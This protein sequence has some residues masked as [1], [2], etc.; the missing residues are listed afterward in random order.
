MLHYCQGSMRRCSQYFSDFLKTNWVRRQFYTWSGAVQKI[1]PPKQ[2]E[3]NFTLKAIAGIFCPK[4]PLP[5]RYWNPGIKLYLYDYVQN[6]ALILLW[7][8]D[9]FKISIENFNEAREWWVAIISK[10]IVVV[11]NLIRKSCKH[12]ETCENF[13]LL[14]KLEDANCLNLMDNEKKQDQF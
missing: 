5:L 4:V 2:K 8:P 3:V 6:S 9:A 11:E 14:I 13:A 1:L 12:S 7:R 10:H